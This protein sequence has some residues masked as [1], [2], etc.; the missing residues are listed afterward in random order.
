MWFRLWRGWRNTCCG[1]WRRRLHEPPCYPEDIAAGEKFQELAALLARLR[2]PGG[3]P[4]DR[5]QTFDSI[6]PYT[7]E[8]TYEVLDAIDR[9][10]WKGLAEELGDFML[11]AV[12]YAEMAAEQGL[13][14]IEDA[15]DAV[16]AKLIRRHPHVFGEESADSAGDVKR[17]WADVKAAEKKG[18]NAGL[19]AGVPRALPAL[20]EGQQIAS[21]AAGVGFDWE[22]PEQ[23]L[24][25]LR[26]ELAEFDQ[27]RRGGSQ[28]EME[29]E[30]GDLLFVLVNLAR[31][32]KVDPEQALRKTNAKFRER[33][34]YIER[35]LAERGRK[36][37]DS[38]IEEMEALWQEA[39]LTGN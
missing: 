35:K 17:I 30:M 18:E 20:V 13:F 39:K 24:D 8:E 5:E 16:N 7:L 14:T 15:L 26:E 37:G 36:A 32:V 38:N 6:K 2:A 10:D 23:V 25:K 21:R 11:Q 29:D 1:P 9:R 31:F 4:W 27:A 22:N 34:G 33:F 28:A 3:C 19:L 12:F